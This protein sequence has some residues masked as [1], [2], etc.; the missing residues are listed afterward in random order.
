MRVKQKKARLSILTGIRADTWLIHAVW[1]TL[2]NVVNNKEITKMNSEA[3]E[4]RHDS[5]KTQTN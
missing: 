3:R 5:D 1:K 2:Y 4:W